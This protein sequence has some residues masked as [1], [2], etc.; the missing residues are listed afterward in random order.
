MRRF[1]LLLLFL[2]VGFQLYAQK[3][4]D[5]FISVKKDTVFLF[6][7]ENPEVGQ[8]FYVE[9]KDMNDEKFI[10]LTESLVTPVLNPLVFADILGDDYHF[11]LNSLDLSS[12]QEMLLRLRTDR[13]ASTVY[14][15]LFHKVGTAL[16]RFYKAGG[17]T[18]GET[19]RYRIVIVD[20]QEKVLQ[21][22]E[23]EVMIT[24]RIPHTPEKVQYHQRQHSVVMEWDY[25]HWQPGI[26][27]MTV[28]FYVYRKSPG[29]SYHR[30]SDKIL[31][32]LDNVT[33]QYIDTRVEIGKEYT[34]KMTAVDA[35]GVESKSS[36]E[37]TI[38][39][40][41]II[42]PAPPVGLVAMPAEN[43]VE[44]VWNLSPELDIHGYKVYRW[45]GVEED[46]VIISEKNILF[47]QPHFIDMTCVSGQQ[48]YYA[49]SA[50]DTAGNESKHSNRMAA[51]PTDRTPPGIP[52]N[53]EAIVK[54]NVVTLSWVAPED[55][56]I[57]GYRI[58]RGLSEDRHHQVYLTPD[59]IKNTNYVDQGEADHK[60]VP[61]QRYC[62][63][64]AALDTLWHYGKQAYV[65]VAVPDNEPPAPP[66]AIIIENDQGTAFTLQWNSSPSLD[67]SGYLVYRGSGSDIDSIGYFP[68]M[69][70]KFR[71]TDLSKGK[72]YFYHIIA[73][74]TVGNQ[75]EP[76]VSNTVFFRDFSAPPMVQYVSVHK[77]ENGMQINWERVVD[78]DL[79]EYRVY[80]SSSPTGTF[81]KIASVPFEKL[82]FF[83]KEGREDFWYRIRA[84]D[85]SGNESEN[86]TP[87][88][89][90][91]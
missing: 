76:A 73:L 39:V 57:L 34:Y 10:R 46:S 20:D 19:Y 54:D 7:K 47:D 85:S 90:G 35:S 37:V 12:P 52:Q 89:A 45:K 65:W 59:P 17:H 84:V 5:C 43:E 26:E 30:L 83:D 63:S 38:K 21:T 66:G 86:S 51:F 80:R 82:Q 11:I 61:G 29:G 69:A 28:Q 56:D 25:P 68:S 49:V 2:N 58:T 71:D 33:H 67:I 60:I 81:K 27:D 77:S 40:K 23:K 36:E 15:M 50:L 31:L 24:E 9:R 13:F 4:Q 75:S 88:K 22:I 48:Y 6:L 32:R 70:R 79:T 41:D 1:I 14:M 87:Q 42:A 3:K 53:L 72:E 16:G 18:S 55:E 91:R 74:D 44:L 62:Y 78:F 64:V 8:G